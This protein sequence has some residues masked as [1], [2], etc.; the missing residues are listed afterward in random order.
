MAT[1]FFLCTLKCRHPH[2]VIQVFS[3]ISIKCRYV[4][5]TGIVALQKP[6]EIR[7]EI[8]Q[9]RMTLKVGESKVDIIMYLGKIK[10][11]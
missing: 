5:D 11:I 9:F 3:S 6:E 1:I 10:S 4:G 2:H 7:L 8:Q